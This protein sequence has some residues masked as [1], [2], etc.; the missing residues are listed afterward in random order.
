MGPCPPHGHGTHHYY[1][2]L[3]AL[4]VAKLAVKDRARCKEVWEAARLRVI[5]TTELIGTYSR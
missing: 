2:G 3:L 5:A 4:D 1:F